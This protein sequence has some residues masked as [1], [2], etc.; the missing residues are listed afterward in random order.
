MSR[1]GQAHRGD[2]HSITSRSGRFCLSFV[3]FRGEIRTGPSRA[4]VPG[5]WIPGGYA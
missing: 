2:H 5:G 1:D 4:Q 3:A